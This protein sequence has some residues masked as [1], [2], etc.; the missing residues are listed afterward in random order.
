MDAV[1]HI[2]LRVERTTAPTVL[3]ALLNAI[4]FQ[5]NLDAIDPVT[6]DILDTPVAVASSLSAPAAGSKAGTPVPAEVEIRREI[7]AKIDEFT[8]TFVDTRADGGEIAVVFFQRKNRKG[9]FAV[10]EALVPWEEHLITLTF[11][12]RATQNPLPSALRQVLTF[13]AKHK[14]GVPSALGSPDQST[15]SHEIIV[16]PPPPA[17]LFNRSA[18]PHPE[19]LHSP[20][21][22]ETSGTTST[23]GDTAVAPVPVRPALERRSNSPMTAISDAGT[24]A[25]GYLGQAKDGLLAVAPATSSPDS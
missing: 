25:M 10:T 16:A 3:R 2:K 11:V 20:R 17:E 8:K 5:R 7:L 15:L 14:V 24:S 23:T 12:T 9:W 13:C 21:P 6:V 19:R 22:A 18:S 1:N 4:F